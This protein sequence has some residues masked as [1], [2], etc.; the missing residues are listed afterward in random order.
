MYHNVHNHVHVRWQNH[1]Y[2]HRTCACIT[3]HYP[4]TCF[5]PGSD[6]WNVSKASSTC[7]CMLP[8]AYPDATCTYIPL[9][10]CQV[11][12][13]CTF[14]EIAELCLRVAVRVLVLYTLRWEEVHIIAACV[15]CR[16]TMYMYMVH[17]HYMYSAMCM[18]VYTVYCTFRFCCCHTVEVVHG[19]A[20]GH[21]YSVIN[22]YLNA[23]EPNMP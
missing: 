16:I 2:E 15:Y 23:G 20:C 12:G 14:R 21:S 4:A 18:H 7:T 19:N 3:S 13:C 8:G 22:P 11:R 5:A 1:T 6:Y 9:R 10:S 17:T